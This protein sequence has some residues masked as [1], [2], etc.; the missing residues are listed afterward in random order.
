MH[1]AYLIDYAGIEAIVNRCVLI[2]T[3][4]IAVD[5][6]DKGLSKRNVG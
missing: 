1:A 5:S 3:K 4:L 2:R 6:P